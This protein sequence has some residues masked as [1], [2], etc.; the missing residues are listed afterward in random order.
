[1]VNVFAMVLEKQTFFF[2]NMVVYGTEG[3]LGI[4][5]TPPSR[6]IALT[7]DFFGGLSSGS[8]RNKIQKHDH[9]FSAHGSIW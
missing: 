7:M 9:S 3:D 5:Y 4:F 6:T 2:K 8:S 1:M